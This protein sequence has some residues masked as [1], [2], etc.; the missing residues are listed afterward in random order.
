MAQIALLQVGCT[1]QQIIDTINALI[2]AVTDGQAGAVSYNDLTDK[3][4]ING[5][6]LAGSKTTDDLD[7]RIADASDF[8][9]YETLWASKTY[10]DAATATATA[11]AQSAVAAAL[12]GKLDK[13]LG[14][15]QT[16]RSLAGDDYI[17]VFTDA[18]V[19][20]VPVD[21][22][23]DNMAVRTV[24][25]ES[26]SKAVAS[27]LDMIELRGDRDGS[28]LVFAAK[29]SFVPGT[30]NLFL[31]GQRLTAG[32]DYSENNG[33]SVTMLDYAPEASDTLV[34]VAVTK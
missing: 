13:D 9:T 5:V 16:V 28:N 6:E 29:P 33:S 17:T 4:S 21:S 1:G 26:L 7:I 32:T 15:I 11:A 10:A 12:D 27:H 34:L 14:N 3:P 18:G 19:R 2:A 31:N 25:A 20:K 24:S 30:S 22:L 23:S 8:S